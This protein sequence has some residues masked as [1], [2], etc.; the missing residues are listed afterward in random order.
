METQIKKNR[1][2]NFELLRIISMLMII[3][4]H[5]AQHSGI[6]GWQIMYEPFSFNTIWA[7]LF[8]IYGQLGV[9]L[10]IILSSWFLCDSDRIHVKKLILINLE[11]IFYTLIF[12][13]IIKING[14]EILGKKQFIEVFLTPWFNG[15]WFVLTYFCFYMCIPVL[16]FYSKRVRREDQGKILLVLTFLIPFMQL[17]FQKSEFGN[18][19]TFIYLYLLCSYLKSK[20]DNFISKNCIWIFLLSFIFI[21]G[22]CFAINI[23]G[24]KIGKGY[25]RV[26]QIYGQRN[27]LVM[28]E[29]ISLFYIFKNYVNIGYR[30]IINEIAKTTLGIYILHESW[31]FV[32]YMQG[33]SCHTGGLLFEYFL[34]CGKYFYNSRY[35]GLYFLLV[36]VGIFTFC[37]II[38]YVRIYIFD[39]KL[40]GNDRLLNSFCQKFDNWY[41]LTD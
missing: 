10:F 39:K 23:L 26:T 34:K 8:G 18:I 22:I 38:E 36:V 12:Y 16:H 41:K 11:C 6:G 31:L 13:V 17:I 20:E 40:I 27:V 33:K 5:L 35:F 1:K 30:K 4:S 37:S 24:H 25:T 15:Y 9:C 7:Y 29:A 19:G 28:L 2:S 21:L 32:L 3:G 14:F